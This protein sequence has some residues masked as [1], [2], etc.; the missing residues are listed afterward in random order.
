MLVDLPDTPHQLFIGGG[1]DQSMSREHMLTV[2]RLD[3][4]RHTPRQS[5]TEGEWIAGLTQHLEMIVN[6]RIAHVREW[7]DQNLSRFQ[8]V[9]GGGVS[10]ARIDELKRHF[11][12][13]MVDL[14]GNVQLC[15]MACAECQLR[16]VQSRLHEG[17]HDC[18]SDHL[19]V[20]KC[21]FCSALELQEHRSC[22]MR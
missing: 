12:S 6:L 10:H 16:C 14:R 20:H 17:L 5:T 15:G 19:C 2:L 11:E 8:A 4:E 3:W 7:L 22:T 13:S 1:G 18:Q 9:G 21:D